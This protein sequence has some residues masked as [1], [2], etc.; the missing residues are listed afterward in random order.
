MA[1]STIFFLGLFVTM[2]LLTGV[3]FTAYEMKKMYRKSD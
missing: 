2:L 3:G 1:D